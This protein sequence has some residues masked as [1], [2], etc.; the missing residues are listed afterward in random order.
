MRCYGLS[1][2]PTPCKVHWRR[3]VNTLFSACLTFDHTAYLLYAEIHVTIHLLSHN[4]W[5][6]FKQKPGFHDFCHW[7]AK[8]RPLTKNLSCTKHCWFNP[9]PIFF[10]WSKYLI[11]EFFNLKLYL[12]AVREM[13]SQKGSF[14]LQFSQEIWIFCK[15]WC[16]KWIIWLISFS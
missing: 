14:F 12:L 7:H 16:Q 8:P 3:T 5:L 13:L 9:N 2:F 6:G 4:G 10:Q 15:I 11:W 1:V